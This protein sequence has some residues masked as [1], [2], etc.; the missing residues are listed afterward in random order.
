MKRKSIVILLIFMFVL[1]GAFSATYGATQGQLKEELENVQSDQKDVSQR[2]TQVK[3]DID[4]LN[5][6][7]E[8]LNAEI[9]QA[10][11]K[12][13]EAQEAIAK[14]QQEMEEREDGLNER[15]RVMYKNGSIGYVDVLLGSGSVSEFISNMDMI[16]KIYENDMEVLETLREESEELERAKEELETQK[17]QLDEKKA[18]LDA[19]KEEL[20]S[21]KAELEAEEDRLLEEAQALSDEIL[22]MTNPDSEYV[23]G[24]TWVWPV[25]SSRYI[26]S[27]FGWRIHPVYNTWK[28]HSGMD[29]GASSGSNILACAAGTVIK[30]EW[31]GGYGNCVMIDHGGGLVTLY[32]HM[33][34]RSVS[35]GDAVSAG[36]LIGKVGSTGVST[37][38]HLHLEFRQNGTLIEPLNYIG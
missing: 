4:S 1:A 26:T 27:Y 30:S 23:G 22:S 17:A 31:Y 38:P 6:K 16:Q 33:S 18:Q 10:N 7:V 24:D 12:I 2:L 21:L 14:K 13:E 28:Y 5:I 34:S 37:G 25:P 9:N 29:I 3:E 20:D 36:Q 32:G 11:Q 19:D 15:L 35:K 8:D